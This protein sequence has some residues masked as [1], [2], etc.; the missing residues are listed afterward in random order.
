MVVESNLGMLLMLIQLRS[1]TPICLMYPFLFLVLF[2][3]LSLT[4]TDNFVGFLL[5]KLILK[6]SLHP[7]LN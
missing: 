2:F 4:L 5:T 6:N 7:L 1:K 3:G